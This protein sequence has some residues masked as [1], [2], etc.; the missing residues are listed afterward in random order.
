MK[1][2]RCNTIVTHAVVRIH[3]DQRRT[4]RCARVSVA[5]SLVVSVSAADGEAIVCRSSR[6]LMTVVRFHAVVPMAHGSARHLLL[7]LVRPSVFHYH[8]PPLY[9]NV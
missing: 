3:D 6:R 5:D 4:T 1:R 2:S 7:R 9:Q 8:R